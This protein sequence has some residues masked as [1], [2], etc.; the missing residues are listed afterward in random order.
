[1][2]I[3]IIRHNE[4]VDLYIEGGLIAENISMVEAASHIDKAY[5]EAIRNSSDMISQYA[6]AAE[7]GI[8]QAE[9]ALKRIQELCAGSKERHSFQGEG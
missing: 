4:S 2:L 9:H 1:M 8:A 6:A 3:E 5:T 7:A